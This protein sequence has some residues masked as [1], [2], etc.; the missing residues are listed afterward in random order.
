[1]SILPW[2]NDYSSHG[3]GLSVGYWS[4][5]ATIPYGNLTGKFEGVAQFQWR[6]A[7]SVDAPK[8]STS[9]VLRRG[10]LPW[11][12]QV[13]DAGGGQSRL[14]N[15]RSLS[16][17]L[18]S[19]S[20]SSRAA[21]SPATGCRGRSAARSATPIFSSPASVSLMPARFS[22]SMQR[23]STARSKHLLSRPTR[24]SSHDSG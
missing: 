6:V 23:C 1:M 21:L 4:T 2:E 9:V 17:C 3:D 22:H 8:L 15:N 10:V 18:V 20:S 16:R 5:H 19:A 11:A 12:N 7:A 13:R 14:R 24:R